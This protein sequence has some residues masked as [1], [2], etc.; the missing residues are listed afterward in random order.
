MTKN[1][2]L[3]ASCGSCGNEPDARSSG[4]QDSGHGVIVLVRSGASFDLV[5]QDEIGAG[6][7]RLGGG[8][9][10][11]QFRDGGGGARGG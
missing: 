6:V 2:S 7:A 3:I 8:E 11:T 5:A 1:S 9:V 10:L 4:V